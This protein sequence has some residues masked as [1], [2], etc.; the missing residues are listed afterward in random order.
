MR[1]LC[2]LA[3]LDTVKLNERKYSFSVTNRKPM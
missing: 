3:T 1:K 2:G